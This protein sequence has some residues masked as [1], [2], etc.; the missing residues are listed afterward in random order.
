MHAFIIICA[1]KTEQRWGGKWHGGERGHRVGLS[2]TDADFAI[3][4]SVIDDI[5]DDGSYAGVAEL[6]NGMSRHRCLDAGSATATT[7]A[8]ITRI[9][10]DADHGNN[11]SHR[12]LGFRQRQNHPLHEHPISAGFAKAIIGEQRFVQQDAYIEVADEGWVEI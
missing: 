7:T 3:N 5:V 6:V 9:I 11:N 12:S 10:F 8:T 4:D 2:P 1:D